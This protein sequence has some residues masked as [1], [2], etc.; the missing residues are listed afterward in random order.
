MAIEESS[1][2]PGHGYIEAPATGCSVTRDRRTESG[3]ALADS[4]AGSHR[5]AFGRN[6][7]DLANPGKMEALVTNPASA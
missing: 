5:Q 6:I 4:K 7:E 2:H 1:F 3:T